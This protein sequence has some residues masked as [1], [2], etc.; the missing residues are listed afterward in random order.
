MSWVWEAKTRQLTRETQRPSWYKSP[1]SQTC[2]HSA[3]LE[4]PIWNNEWGR[5]VTTPSWMRS[6]SGSETQR[7]ELLCSRK[8]CLQGRMQLRRKSNGSPR[9][10]KIKQSKSPHA[11]ST[12][13]SR[14][15]KA[16]RRCLSTVWT[17]SVEIWQCRSLKKKLKSASLC[18]SGRSNR[19]CC[20]FWTQ[21]RG[22]SNCTR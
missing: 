16:Y 11:T 21:R 7:E 3:I 9:F 8:V 4:R 20:R 12:T 19:W 13:Q 2:S 6:R 14:C 5:M 10:R 1:S 18:E 17:L 15:R 22:I